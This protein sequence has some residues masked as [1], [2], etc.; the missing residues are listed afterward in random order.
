MDAINRA[1]EFMVARKLVHA[2]FADNHKVDPVKLADES[3]PPK[4]FMDGL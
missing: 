1:A 2:S 4:Q 3:I